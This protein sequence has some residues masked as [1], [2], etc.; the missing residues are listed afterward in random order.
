MDFM[1]YRIKNMEAF[2][3]GTVLGGRFLKPNEILEVTETD[4]VKIRNSGGV[5]EVLE[6]MIPN[7]KKM[8]PVVAAIVEEQEVAE[9]EEAKAKN[10]EEEAA[11][12]KT[13]RQDAED[14]AVEAKPKR[15]AGRPRKNAS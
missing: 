13:Y 2:K 14:R 6:T 8:N 5:V 4:L 12:E 9:E 15:K 11:Q 7:P 3:D 1:K 10:V